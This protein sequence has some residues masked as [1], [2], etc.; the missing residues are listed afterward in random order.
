LNIITNNSSRPIAYKP[1][2][3]T[4]G[5][6]KILNPG[7]SAEADGFYDSQF[8]DAPAGKTVRKIR[9]VTDVVI[10]DGKNGKVGWHYGD[11]ISA[12][13]DAVDWTATWYGPGDPF[14][15]RHP[16]WSPTC[17]CK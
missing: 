9:D 16:D 13:A 14:L 8:E 11:P 6:C 12:A 10:V 2:H 1:E 17:P 4:E 5:K 15:A 7:S 3:D